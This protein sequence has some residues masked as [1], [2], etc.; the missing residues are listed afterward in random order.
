MNQKNKVIEFLIKNHSRNINIINFIKNYDIQHIEQIGDSVIVKGTSDRNW[1]YIS[2]KSEEELK[3]IKNRLDYK[4]K[5]NF[6]ILLQF[7]Q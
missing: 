7:I 6:A 5:N 2:S 4:D 1:I 3:I